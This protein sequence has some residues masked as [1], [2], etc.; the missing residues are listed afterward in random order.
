MGAGIAPAPNYPREKDSWNMRILF[1][2]MAM[3]AL[4]VA[5]AAQAQV[6]GDPGQRAWLQCRACHTLKKGEPNKV[7]PNL[8]GLFGAKAGTLRPDFRY[9]DALKTS[10][11]VWNDKTIDRWIA[12]PAAFI[13]GNRMAYAGNAKPE[14]R[15]ALVAYMKRET[16]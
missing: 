9:S 1:S 13:K 7:G 16:K 6:A 3:P 12:N 10:G 2:V 8:H 15:A 11:V 5:G 4:L 14:V